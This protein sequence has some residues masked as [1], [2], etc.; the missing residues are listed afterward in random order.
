MIYA[1]LS[2]DAFYK[3]C[4]IIFVIMFSETIIEAKHAS[5]QQ[6]ELEQR[7]LIAKNQKLEKQVQELK[8]LLGRSPEE[9]SKVHNVL[10]AMTEA[11]TK[12]RSI[13]SG[14]SHSD[15]VTSKE[16]EKKKLEVSMKKV[17]T[18]DTSSKKN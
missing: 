9:G 11:V 15:A 2:V 10:S 14:G 16:V 12:R 8:E 18:K 4:Y 6:Y 5:A 17:R 13:G 1:N 3:H 7:N